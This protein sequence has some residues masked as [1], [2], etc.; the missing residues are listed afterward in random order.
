[1]ASFKM[2]IRFRISKTTEIDGSRLG[3]FESSVKLYEPSVLAGVSIGGD[4]GA[5]TRHGRQ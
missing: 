5:A 3:R 4:A 1:M 2:A